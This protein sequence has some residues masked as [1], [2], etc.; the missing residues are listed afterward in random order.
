MNKHSTYFFTVLLFNLHAMHA[1]APAPT[2]EAN[3]IA[4]AASSSAS[5]TCAA[6]EPT[7]TSQKEYMPPI[8]GKI[9][10]RKMFYLGE[11]P[12]DLLFHKRLRNVLDKK[13]QPIPLKPSDVL[14]EVYAED[15]W[16]VERKNKPWA[17]HNHQ[18]LGH[19]FPSS[20]PLSMLD[21][22]KEGDSLK[23]KLQLEGGK[24]ARVQLF[25]HRLRSD[26]F[27]KGLNRLKK[28]FW[29]VPEYNCSD[30]KR[31]LEKFIIVRNPL[32]KQIKPLE[33]QLQRLPRD[34]SN[35]PPQALFNAY[36]MRGYSI[37]E[38]VASQ[39]PDTAA[40]RAGLERQI[41]EKKQEWI[42]SGHELAGF[43]SVPKYTHGPNGFKYT[44]KKRDPSAASSASASSSTKASSDADSSSCESDQE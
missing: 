38:A 3:T 14:V 32:Y 37:D 17:E 9:A 8:E 18:I 42:A 29:D 1:S 21:G 33:D 43:G 24:K 28:R 13:G 2:P 19:S 10:V 7:S 4:A 26:K 41:K 12:Q 35:L 16:S 23:F 25:C 6:T 36:I 22:K 44:P 40:Q 31:L 34:L 5:S 27:E 20:L 30:E 15:L 11:D 39:D